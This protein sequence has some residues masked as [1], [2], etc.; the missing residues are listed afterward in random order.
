MDARTYVFMCSIY[1]H[2]RNGATVVEIKPSATSYLE[3]K[4]LD[5]NQSL[6]ALREQITNTS[7]KT[8]ESV[9]K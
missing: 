7:K 6:L 9:D 3:N 1:F 4:G 2:L 8:I 5:T